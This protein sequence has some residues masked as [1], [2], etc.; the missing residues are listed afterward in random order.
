[1]TPDPEPLRPIAQSEETDLRN[2]FPW[3]VTTSTILS[4]ASSRHLSGAAKNHTGR[5]LQA[6]WE[7]LRHSLAIAFCCLSRRCNSKPFSSPIPNSAVQSSTKPLTR[8]VLA[9]ALL[10][11]TL[12]TTTIV[13]KLPVLISRHWSLPAVLLK[14]PYALADDYLGST[15][16]ALPDSSVKNSSDAALLYSRALFPGYILRLLRCDHGTKP[17]FI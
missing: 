6:N 8:P 9:A 14:G 2:C 7:I 13:G 1:V 15:N 5:S 16:G 12:F 10:V 11:A 4:I 17:Q 3:S